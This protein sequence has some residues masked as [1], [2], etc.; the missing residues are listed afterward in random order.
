MQLLLQEEAKSPALVSTSATGELQLNHH[1]FPAEAEQHRQ[2]TVPETDADQAGWD[3]QELPLE[4]PAETQDTAE[5]DIQAA[6]NP[7][8]V[9][10]QPPEEPQEENMGTETGP[11]TVS[12]GTAGVPVSDIGEAASFR[13]SSVKEVQE[14]GDADSARSAEGSSQ[15]EDQ[16]QPLESTMAFAA[17]EEQSSASKTESLH[18]DTQPEVGQHLLLGL[19]V[20]LSWQHIQITHM[21]WQKLHNARTS[22]GRSRDYL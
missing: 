4:V 6:S 8:S 12:E 10:E 22:R 7:N 21:I 13:D 9:L 14:G 19:E 17:N 2:L 1:D 16:T 15:L 20:L 18:G 11:D 5:P 3:N